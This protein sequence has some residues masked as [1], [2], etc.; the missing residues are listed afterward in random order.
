MILPFPSLS[1]SVLIKEFNRV[2]AFA[3]A[4][5]SRQTS[6]QHRSLRQ[7]GLRPAVGNCSAVAGGATMP[8]VHVERYIALRQTLGFKLREVSMNP[9]AF[10]KFAA[11]SGDTHVR[12]CTAVDWAT[13]ASSPNVRHIRAEML[14]SLAASYMPKIRLMRS[15]STRSMAPDADA[16]PISTHRRN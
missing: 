13:E 11:A 6:E 16:C 10:A 12:V 7:G 14:H 4:H 3:G 15:Q 9:R 1:A 5:E 2:S 8:I